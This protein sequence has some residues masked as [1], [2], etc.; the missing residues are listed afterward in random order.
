MGKQ[1]RQRDAQ[2]KRSEALDKRRKENETGRE[3][4][5]EREREGG[6]ERGTQ[7]GV[8]IA[9]CVFRRNM[10]LFPFATRFSRALQLAFVANAPTNSTLPPSSS[11]WSALL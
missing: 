1:V 11:A 10:G 7:H 9:G 8:A 2:R 4:E 3:R 6:R 5:I